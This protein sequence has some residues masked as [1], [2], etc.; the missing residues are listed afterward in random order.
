MLSPS[1]TA[2]VQVL[3]GTGDAEFVSLTSGK[4]V[5]ATSARA[6]TVSTPVGASVTPASVRAGDID[7]FWTVRS[8][9]AHPPPGAALAVPF[10]VHSGFDEEG[11]VA[12]LTALLCLT[13]SPAAPSTGVLAFDEDD[14]GAATHVAAVLAHCLD[15]HSGSTEGLTEA[16]QR[17]HLLG[18]ELFE[19]NRAMKALRRRE[20][21]C[22]E[23]WRT[24]KP[25]PPWAE[26]SGR[27]CRWRLG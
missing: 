25:R 6:T 24:F 22:E 12:P 3:L 15:V 27:E 1:S 9:T 13:R 17:L 8:C 26:R 7:E 16:R 10:Q 5:Y 14:A 4:P 23:V 20:G 19:S 11:R 2:L 18:K 21:H